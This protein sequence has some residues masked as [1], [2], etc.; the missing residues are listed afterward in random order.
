MGK[1]LMRTDLSRC[2]CQKNHSV[3]Y[4]KK[5]PKGRKNPVKAEKVTTEA[6]ID[7]TQVDSNT[8]NVEEGTIG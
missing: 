2:G 6:D 3:S 1:R 7:T 8:A 4:G 5:S